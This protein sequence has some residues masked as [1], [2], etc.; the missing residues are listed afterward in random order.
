MIIYK[1]TNI[2]SNKVYIGQTVKSLQDRLISHLKQSKVNAKSKFHR[3]LKSYGKDCF[4][5]EILIEVN[6]KSELDYFEKYYI[7]EYNSIEYG[8]NMVEGGTGG[9][10]EY[11]VSKNKLKRGKKWEDIY[12]KNGLEKMIMSK[13]KSSKILK[14]YNTNLPKDEHITRAKNAN[15]YRII[16]GYKHTEITKQKIRNSQKG[17]TNEMRYGKDGAILLNKKIS[18]TTKNA[19]KNVDRELLGKKSVEARILYWNNKHAEQK[20]KIVELKNKKVAV[21][22]IIAHLNISTPTYYKLWNEI[23]K[24]SL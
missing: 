2:K 10:N 23:K 21:K 17:I 3:A 13:E 12:S 9:Y 4:K 18:E 8:Y 19:M 6:N 1:C 20:G 11:A 15:K 5:W 7:K 14:E 24:E 22:E 16:K